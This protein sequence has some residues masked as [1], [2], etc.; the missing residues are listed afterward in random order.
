M[1]TRGPGPVGGRPAPGAAGTGGAA[2][3]AVQTPTTSMSVV[4]HLS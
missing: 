1:T 3:D 2:R 4:A